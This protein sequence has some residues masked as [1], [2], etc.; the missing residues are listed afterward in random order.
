MIQ[1]VGSTTRDE[2]NTAPPSW[3]QSLEQVVQFVVAAIV[4]HCCRFRAYFL[5]LRF[6]VRAF[7]QVVE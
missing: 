6:V 4:R 2:N 7:E 3:L 1:R 5:M